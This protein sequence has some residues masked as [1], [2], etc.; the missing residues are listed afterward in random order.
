MNKFIIYFLNTIM[1]NSPITTRK[2]G[3][4]KVNIT[5]GIDLINGGFF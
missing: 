4:N 5:L 1:L 3:F 2:K